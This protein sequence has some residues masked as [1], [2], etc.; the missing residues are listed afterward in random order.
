MDYT[1]T[2]EIGVGAILTLSLIL[3]L[4]FSFERYNSFKVLS[5]QLAKFKNKTELE[6]LLSEKM[7][8]ISTISS[9]A[10]YVGL[11]GTTLG[12]ILTLNAIDIAD[13]KALIQSL[14]IP[15]LSTAA[16][17][18]VA[19]LGSFFYSILVNKIEFILKRWDIEHG[20]DVK[21]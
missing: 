18:V 14:S 5:S 17:L 6:M 1:Q 7:I 9:N 11:L 4:Y 3:I 16:S 21:K 20:F 15:L 2:I 13:K 10:L 19:I 12:I 8:V